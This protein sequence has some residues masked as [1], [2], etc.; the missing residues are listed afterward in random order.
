MAFYLEDLSTLIYLECDM[1]RGIRPSDVLHPHS[2]SI[3]ARPKLT[4]TK[5]CLP[6]DP[7]LSLIPA[8]QSTKHRKINQWIF[9][10]KNTTYLH[11]SLKFHSYFFCYLMTSSMRWSLEYFYTSLVPFCYWIKIIKEIK[12]ILNILLEFYPLLLSLLYRTYFAS[13][14]NIFIRKLFCGCLSKSKLFFP[15][16]SDC[17]TKRDIEQAIPFWNE[18]YNFSC[19]NFR[20]TRTFIYLTFD[21]CRSS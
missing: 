21:S 4:S 9:T 11:F 8:G 19:V 5:L 13:F 17:G 16:H 1:P 7:F 12:C 3:Q 2:T 6:S 10:L 15:F 14:W 18:Y 20:V